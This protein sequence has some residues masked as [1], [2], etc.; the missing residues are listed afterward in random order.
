MIH[1]MQVFYVV[2]RYETKEGPD[3]IKMINGPFGEW[4]DARD[5]KNSHTYSSDKYEIME[6]EIEVELC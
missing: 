1:K 5:A 3:F 6:Q 4:E 2:R